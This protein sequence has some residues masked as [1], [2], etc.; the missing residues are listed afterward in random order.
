MIK[1]FKV[2]I[3]SNKT[4]INKEPSKKYTTKYNIYSNKIPKI[5]IFLASL[6]TYKSDD[7]KYEGISLIKDAKNKQKNKEIH[8]LI[9]V[10]PV[11][12]C[13]G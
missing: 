6:K 8:Y 13:S 1:Y 3:F 4:I 5:S 11:H 9:K 12:L 7:I 10:K 2:S